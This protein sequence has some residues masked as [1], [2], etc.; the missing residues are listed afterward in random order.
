MCDDVRA[1]RDDSISMQFSR[2]HDRVLANHIQAVDGLC[3][4]VGKFSHGRDILLPITLVALVELFIVIR[5]RLLNRTGGNLKK[6]VD[7]FL[8]YSLLRHFTTQLRAQ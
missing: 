7:P 6:M 3:D 5:P 8:A 4:K 1:E 2:W